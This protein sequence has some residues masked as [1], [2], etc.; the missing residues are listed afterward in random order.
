MTTETQCP[1]ELRRAYNYDTFVAEN[2]QPWFRFHEAPAPGDRI[3]DFQL[4]T[5]EGESRSLKR[6]IRGNQ[7]TI[8]EFGS[9]T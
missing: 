5:L 2:Y 3:A 1:E 9:F 6:L 7:L 8:L 4:Q